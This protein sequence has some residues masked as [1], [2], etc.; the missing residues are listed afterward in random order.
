MK[1]KI[2]GLVVFIGLTVAMPVLAY[3]PY[4][5]HPDLT[6]EMAKLYNLKNSVAD[7]HISG[8]EIG[9]MRDG[10]IDEDDPPRWINH[11]YDPINKV[12]WSGKHFGN[13]TPEEGL[14]FGAD[15]APKASMASADWV[16]DQ[17]SQALYGDEQGNQTWQ[18]A[19]KSFID[20][21]N[22]AAFVALGHVLHL[23]EDAS[24]PDH[25]RDDTH[26][27]LFGDAGSPYEKYSREYTNSNKLNL[28]ENL[29][30]SSYIN[31]SNIQEAIKSL[32]T[33]SNNN[34][35]SEDTISN[36]EFN[37]PS[38]SSLEKRFVFIN[39][40][41]RKVLFDTVNDAY[42][43]IESDPDNFTI[44]DKI[45]VLPSYR[46]HL[47]PKAVLTG[48]SVI[49]LFFHDVEYYK[50]HPD[51]LEPIVPDSK[52]P[53]V[54][55]IK[56]SPKKIAIKISDTAS[57]LGADVAKLTADTTLAV[58]STLSSLGIKVSLGPTPASTQNNTQLVTEQTD[59]VT[60]SAKTVNSTEPDV[61]MVKV[62]L[63]NAQTGKIIDK[64]SL[65][66]VKTETGSGTLPK[67]TIETAQPKTEPVIIQPKPSYIL[68]IGY[69]GGNSAPTSVFDPV[70]VISAANTESDNST[71][72]ISS[73]TS[74][75]TSTTE[76]SSSTPVVIDI[77]PPSIPILKIE[78]QTNVSSTNIFIKMQSFDDLS[79]VVYFDLDFSTNTINWISLTA[80]TASTDFSFTGIRGS[81]YYFRSRA[82]DIVGNISDWSEIA[83]STFVN[84]SGEV[85][86][87]E[88]AW[89]GTS[90]DYPNDEWFELYNN[91]DQNI[92]LTNWKIFASG[93][94]ISI[95]KVFNKSILAKSYYLFKRDRDEVIRSIA[96]D[97]IYSLSINGFNNNGEKLE[98]FKP[99]GEKSDEVDA[100]NGWF[101]GDVIKYRSMERINP[102]KNGSDPLNWQSNKGFRENGRGYSG[103]YIYGSPKRSNFGFITLDGIQDEDVRRLT[104]VNNPYILQF[105]NIPAGKTL[106]IDPGVIIKN[107][108]ITSKIDVN[109]TLNAVGSENK[110][111]VF[112]SGKDTSV[113]GGIIGIWTTTTPFSLDWQGVW[114]HSG[115]V[116]NLE[117]INFRYAGHGFVAPPNALPI[118]QAVRVE[119][120]SL[121]IVSSTFSDNGP[122]VIYSKFSSTTI[123]GSSISNGDKALTSDSSYVNISDS[124]FVNFSNITGP[125][126]ITGRWPWFKNLNFANNYLNASYLSGV[127]ITEPEVNVEESTNYLMGSLTVS[128][129][130]TLNI[131]PGASI[132]LLSH[133]IMTINGSLLAVGTQDKPITFSGYPSSTYW[134]S[135][136]FFNSNS[137]LSFVNIKNGGASGSG[138]SS[139]FNEGT[140]VTDS[141]SLSISNTNIWDSE[142]FNNAIGAKNSILNISNT[143]IDS[144]IKKNSTIG[145]NMRFGS[146]NINNVKFNNL[147]LGI[148]AGNS[149][150]PLPILKKKNMSTSSFSNVD[151]LVEPSTW[152]NA[153]SLTP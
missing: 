123:S 81:L 126:Q 118:N 55:A 122:L 134:K 26:A 32:A 68:A 11:F 138:L 125:M 20:G 23:V 79:S 74:E 103:S 115:S 73:S 25:T 8:Q 121:S 90:A 14:K 143:N 150:D 36:D 98:L 116:G 109:G 47:F 53:L 75:V 120:A 13:L 127:T 10:A 110:K 48:A 64:P 29:K 27:D 63:V 78:N 71:N 141:S 146:L 1:T 93:K 148:E 117:N 56:H 50:Q 69:T 17:K 129:S 131:F 33:Y 41:E 62:K 92:D 67:S 84:W 19:V 37:K 119:N 21:D 52:E 85:V 97:S 3:S 151:Y 104:I 152:W 137:V 30:N 135:L 66:N 12:G 58:N 2:G 54:T 39:K 38:I 59:Q 88:V 72:N 77:I 40:K 86:I 80:S 16:I 128:A 153:V 49:N 87:N 130:S 65:S 99:D 15:F 136:K 82:T 107:Y 34:F 124:S 46:S 83:S 102:A 111:I 22:K 28:V 44:E 9:W 6:E 105:Y 89:A 96:A 4:Y 147:L 60:V 101:A 106:I 140:I 149:N 112:T 94:Q 5:T 35:F 18:K 144:P 108:Y 24:V 70:S 51:Q 139:R 113:S 145:V 7:L 142:A 76:T 45:F 95:S 100:A 43:A 31:F 133:D 114:F 42:L 91:T 132:Y 57:R 61:Q